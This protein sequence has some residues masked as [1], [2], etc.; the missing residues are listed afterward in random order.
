MLPLTAVGGSGSLSV[1]RRVFASDQ[2]FELHRLR[3]DR[4]SRG[5]ISDAAGRGNRG[6]K[7]ISKT[8]AES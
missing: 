2:T 5:D 4:H 1:R 8:G 3:S 6:R 7:Q